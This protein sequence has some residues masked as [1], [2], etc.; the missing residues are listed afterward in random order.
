MLIECMLE[1]KKSHNYPCIMA[2]DWNTIPSD[3][4]YKILTRQALDHGELEKLFTSNMNHG[5]SHPIIQ[6]LGA[7]EKVVDFMPQIPELINAYPLKQDDFTTIS[8]DFT[9]VLDHLFLWGDWNVSKRLELPTEEE[10]KSMQPGIPNEEYGSDHVSIFIQVE[11][12][13]DS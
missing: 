8:P 3:A 13:I 1:F 7:F 10:A 5:A 9:G 2:G 4:L 12:S 11:H 6:E